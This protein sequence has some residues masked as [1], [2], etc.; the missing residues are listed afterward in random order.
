MINLPVGKVLEN[1]YDLKVYFPNKEINCSFGDIIRIVLEN[2]E[3]N[4]FIG[5]DGILI[6]NEK[7]DS[8]ELI[9]PYE[10]SQYLK[11]A[12]SKYSEVD[13]S[14]IYLN[15]DDQFL[16]IN[17]GECQSSWSYKYLLLDDF[18]TLIVDY[19]D[20]RMIS[21]RQ[22]DILKV[23]SQDI[24]DSYK[25]SFYTEISFLVKYKFEGSDYERFIDKSLSST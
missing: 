4:Y 10:I 9:V 14:G 22:F 11:D 20:N 12:I 17:I 18:R 21:R 15:H 25:Y 16:K 8:N 6:E 5:K 1:I 7:N 23:T 2:K 24:H 3:I 13:Y 19:P